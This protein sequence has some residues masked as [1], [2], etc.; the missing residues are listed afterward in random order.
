[1]RDAGSA[2]TGR[3]SGQRRIL[4]LSWLTYCLAYMLRVNINVVIPVLAQRFDYTYTQLGLVTSLYFVT[5]MTGQ[6][7]NGYLGD[8]VSSKLLILIGLVGSAL[9]NL[10]V[11]LAPS[12]AVLAICWA[13]NGLVQ[14]M[15]WA[16]LMK[17]L[18]VWFYGYQ[19][20]RVSFIMSFTMIIGYAV[21]WG[22]SSVLVRQVGWAAAFVVPAVLVLVHAVVMAVMFI[23]KPRDTEDQAPDANRSGTQT[24]ASESPPILAFIRMIRLPGLLLIAL[25][26]GIIREGISVWFPTIIASSGRFSSGS[27]WL[28]LVIVP[29]INL[30]GVIFVRRVNQVMK[31][32]TLRTLLLI[33]SLVTASALVLNLFQA[34]WFGMILVVMILLLSLTYGLTPVLTSVIPFQYAHFKRVSLTAGLIDFSI[35]LGAAIAGVVSGWIADHY[36]WD[37]VMLLWLAAAVVGLCLAVWRY[38]VSK[39]DQRHEQVIR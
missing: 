28:I 29:L 37:R 31:N 6:L 8:R 39:G 26:Q 5:Y 33:F 35:Y 16:P 3:D 14:S 36:P 1:M 17:T 25:T 27:P 13:V 9:C 10:G 4:V 32:D 20:G 30:L 34:E 15:L 24:P 7:I 11:A 12:F 2:R 22:F 18:S 38:H 23:S 19:L 21:S